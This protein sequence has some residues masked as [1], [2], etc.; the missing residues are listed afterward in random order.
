MKFDISTIILKNYYFVNYTSTMIFFFITLCLT[1]IMLA[2]SYILSITSLRN[3]EQLSEYECG[4]EPFDNAT[5]RPFE[6][7]F[8]IVGILFLVFDLEIALLFPWV[9]V[10]NQTSIFAFWLGIFFLIILALGFFYEW[11]IGAINWSQSLNKL[12]KIPKNNL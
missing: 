7:H 8:Y 12:I 6:V 1:I 9:F 5:R 11:K 2:L 3:N 10:I 4:F